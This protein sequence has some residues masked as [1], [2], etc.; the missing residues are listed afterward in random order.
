MQ[1]PQR[2]AKIAY[3]QVSLL[4]KTLTCLQKNGL[5]PLY[6][7]QAQ[8]VDLDREKCNLVVATPSASG[9]TMCYNIPVMQVVER[10]RFATALYIFPT[11]ALAQDQLRRLKE[12]FIPDFL[13]DE[14]IAAYDGSTSQHLRSDI[15]RNVRIMLTNP[16]MLNSGILPYHQNFARF[17]RHLQ[18]IV[19]DEAHEY[20]GIFGSH[21]ANVLRRL[22][23]IC[24][25]YGASPKFIMCS[26]TIGNP[27]EL[28]A[29]LT[30][31]DFALVD[32][33]GSPFGGR[34]FV[35][36]NPPIKDQES[37]T[38]RSH[39]M[40]TVD[41]FVALIE[42]RIRSICFARSRRG[43]EFIYQKSKER[44]KE[45][46]PEVAD[47]I[48]PYRAGYLESERRRIEKLLFNGHLLGVC[49]TSALEMGID[50]GGLDAAVLCGYPGSISSTWQ[51]AGRSGRSGL[52]ALSFL[53]AADNPLDQY[54]MRH[55]DFFFNGEYEKS[56]INPFNENIMPKHLLEA[57]WEIPLSNKD[58]AFFGYECKKYIDNLLK[59]D[60]LSERRQHY[61]L[62]A[63]TDCPAKDINLRS[64]GETTF[65]LVDIDSGDFLE[66]MEFHYVIMQGYPGAVYIHQGLTYVITQ[67]DY[68]K[69]LVYTKRQDVSY[70]T[71]T[72]DLTETRVL[73]TLTSH[74]FGHLEILFGEVSVTTKVTGYHCRESGSD[75]LLTT[76][77]LDSPPL[78]YSTQALW[79]NINQ[80]ILNHAREG[81]LDIFGGLHAIEHA[82]IGIMP[83]YALCDRNDIGGVS[84]PCH[85]DTGQASIFI[86]D[87]YAGGMGIAKYTA[88]N[89]PNLWRAALAVIAECP[90]TADDG[91]PA[92]IQSPK[93]GNNNKPLDKRAA[94]NILLELLALCM[95]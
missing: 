39:S 3:P 81:G 26:A 35:F 86:Y 62:A 50:V 18:Y 60:L 47:L 67:V 80:T 83:L 84:T 69:C 4:P 68:D 59:K 28:C 76:V 61:Y 31:L 34:E 45:K 43:A 32:E 58:T 79:F 30:G 41:I 51:Q 25:F 77:E 29:R 91:C 2:Q 15:R 48:M 33:D 42:A 57:A 24:T 8:S 78:T 27:Q 11:K 74:Q 56:L 12:L 23:R 17:L 22:R 53:A 5:Y 46:D 55:S 14:Q 36:W 89:M 19:V 88:E 71:E 65:G 87:G 6:C 92:C 21:V 63:G 49:A 10:E 13:K 90:C 52:K 1:I 70:Y 75:A 44:L 64:A 20:R 40:E 93:C 16:D 37:Q 9:K 66:H 72:Q 7:H 54:I 85:A 94:A 82:V 95:S 38:R 73:N